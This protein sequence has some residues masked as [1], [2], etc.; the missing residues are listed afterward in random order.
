MLFFVIDLTPSR[1]YNN[2]MK[3]SEA[4]M[5]KKLDDHLDSIL[6]MGIPGYDTVIYK[7]GKRIYRRTRGYFGKER[8]N[9]YSCSKPITAVAALQLWEKGLYA[10]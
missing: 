10:L 2:I 6:D 4:I 9:I 1:R 8:F 3:K 7:D 5:F